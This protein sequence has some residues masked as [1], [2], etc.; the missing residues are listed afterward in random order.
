MM[1][2]LEC[3]GCDWSTRL[4][5]EPALLRDLIR[6]HLDEHPLHELKIRMFPEN[7]VNARLAEHKKAITDIRRQLETLTQ[8]IEGAL[9]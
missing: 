1:L 7:H 2:R 9:S 8:R 4:H 3:A 5:D 6:D